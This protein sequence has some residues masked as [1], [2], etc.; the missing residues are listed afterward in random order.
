MMSLPWRSSSCARW[1]ASTSRPPLPRPR[2]PPAGRQDLSQ[3][4]RAVFPHADLRARL[5]GPVDRHLG[6]SVA[7]PARQQEQ[8][9]IEAETVG[10]Q[11][12]EQLV[13][14]GAPKELE[15]A[16]RVPDARSEEHTSE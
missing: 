15:A 1:K 7:A 10:A 16:L 6:D 5:V 12:A 9:D 2:E 14:G 4:P 3:H 11:L 8:L 13:G